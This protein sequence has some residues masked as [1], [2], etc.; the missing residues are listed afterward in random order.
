MNKYNE[1]QIILA[2]QALQQDASLSIRSAAARYSVP[3]KTLTRRRDGIASRR[4]TISKSKKLSESEEQTLVNHIRDL[5][6]K[7][8]SPKPTMV[9]DMANTLRHAR[10]ASPVGHNWVSTFIKRRPELKSSINR[11]YDYRRAL[12]EDPVLIQGWFD[13]VAE[14]KTK[15]GIQ[16][17]DIYNFD[18]AGF[19]I[20]QIDSNIV[21][22]GSD[23]RGAPKTVQPGNRQWVSLIL[24]VNAEGWSVPPYLV[25]SG[26]NH[27]ASWYQEGALKPDWKIHVSENGWTTNDIG[28][29]WLK[30][31]NQ[32]TKDRTT[33]G[34][35]LL[36]LD[37]HES[38]H[39]AQ[40]EEYCR[41][42]NIETIAM[43]PH[44]SHLLQ[45]LDVGCFS[46]LKKAYGAQIDKLIR[47]H[48]THITK[49][50]FF[51]AFRVAFDL[52]IHESNIKAGFRGAGLVP[53][54]PARVIEGLNV[55]LQTPISSR[56]GS[57]ESRN[58]T[59][60]TPRTHKEA[61]SQFKYVRNRL[62]DHPDSSPSKLLESMEQLERGMGTFIHGYTLMKAQLAEAHEANRLVSKRRRAKK[63]RLRQGGSM[64]QK[65]AQ[66]LQ[67]QTEVSQQIKQEEHAG[68]TRGPRTERGP[69]R[70][71][72]CGG[73]G[74]NAR[75]CQIEIES[76]AEEDS[77]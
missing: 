36:V 16:E 25:V 44:S 64:S 70:C 61:T 69:R 23:Q 73:T 19:M 37:G 14:F 68:T 22:T 52:T 63:T 2:L 47:A 76:T 50:D 74:H 65:D 58:S 3:R 54:D 27:L 42:N 33:G 77:D 32:Y 56:P 15:F 71:G 67:E 17:S 20:G 40:F 48:I 34:K 9:K 41:F 45:P 62:T 1:A 30:H 46:P 26:Q 12:C 51:P 60:K 10:A 57:R 55:R 18:E 75:T 35:R 8:F 4:D 28:L 29:D 21:V 38:H 7:G 11:K 24:G 43:P 49:E 66:G 53:F 5:A 6:S 13:R 31:F 39:S 59:S 72:T